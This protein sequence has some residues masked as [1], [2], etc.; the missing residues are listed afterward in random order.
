MNNLI[1]VTEGIIV[2]SSELSA[3]REV[4][5]SQERVLSRSHR[6]SGCSFGIVLLRINEQ[7]DM[8]SKIEHTSIS[9]SRSAAVLTGRSPTFLLRRPPRLPPRGRPLDV[10]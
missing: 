5:I 1:V 3:E 7:R 9:A 4:S 2:D 10:T 8:G 6:G